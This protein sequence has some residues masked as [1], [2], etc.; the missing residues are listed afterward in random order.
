MATKT[1]PLTKLKAQAARLQEEI[2][3]REREN[4]PGMI[5]LRRLLSQYKL[6]VDDFHFIQNRVRGPGRFKGLA[7]KPKYRHP[8]DKS[9]TWAGRGSRPK[10]L[11]EL[12]KKGKKLSDF[13]V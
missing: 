8:T 10:W 5:E 13:A 7:V 2:R 9:L 4:K 12:L 11:A 6:T 3:L 1:I